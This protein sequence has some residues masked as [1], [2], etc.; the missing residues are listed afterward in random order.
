M[1]V[2]SSDVIRQAF[3]WQSGSVGPGTSWE[4]I[5]THGKDWNI[6]FWHPAFHL[7]K[8]VEVLEAFPVLVIRLKDASP[9]ERHDVFLSNVCDVHCRWHN[10]AG[11]W[12]LFDWPKRNRLYSD[13]LK[14]YS[15]QS[16]AKQH[17][18]KHVVISRVAENCSIVLCTVTDTGFFEF[19]GLM[20]RIFYRPSRC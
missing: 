4:A 20:L 3:T 1:S 17:Q 2:Y 19:P 18:T 15:F 8:F 12:L 13:W 11:I 10:P 16:I 9:L 7:D 5:K 6:P 14:H